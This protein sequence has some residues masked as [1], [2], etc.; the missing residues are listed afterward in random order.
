MSEITKEDTVTTTTCKHV[1][2]AAC[3]GK[4][5]ARK[6]TCPLCRGPLT[7]RGVELKRALDNYERLMIVTTRLME[8][9][10]MSDFGSPEYRVLYEEL[11]EL[12]SEPGT[13]TWMILV[14][15]LYVL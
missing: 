5:K 9:R 14:E 12:S 11:V 1:F 13:S 4:W 10:E 8:L 2:H 3:L 6:G 7:N 15:H